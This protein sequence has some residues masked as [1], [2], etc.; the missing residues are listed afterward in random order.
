[1]AE[2]EAAEAA[3]APA[4]G[5]GPVADADADANANVDA[6]T[7]AEAA[8]VSGLGTAPSPST[9]WRKTLLAPAAAVPK[10]GFAEQAPTPSAP[11]APPSGDSTGE[12]RLT[13][14]LALA[15]ALFLVRDLRGV[16]AEA[17][18]PAGLRRT[19]MAGLS[20]RCVRRRSRSR[21]WGKGLRAGG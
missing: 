10:A 9:P 8:A 2:A 14:A 19:G 16:L 17:E 18:R 3:A 20:G 12:T 11:A 1:M 21:G 5:A 6:E 15:G 4:G 13:P 7:V